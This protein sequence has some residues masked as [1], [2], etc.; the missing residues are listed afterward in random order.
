LGMLALGNIAKDEDDTGERLTGSPERR[1]TSIDGALHTAP[2]NEQRVR[3]EPYHRVF[4]EHPGDGILDHLTSVLVDNLKYRRDVL[5][6]GLGFWPPGDRRRY[7]IHERH[8][9]LRVGHDDGVSD[10]RQG[11]GQPFAL[12]LRDRIRLPTLRHHGC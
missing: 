8:P 6:Q 10:T 1:A 4:A 7:G 5:A 12:L 9:P 2:G 3:S 11:D